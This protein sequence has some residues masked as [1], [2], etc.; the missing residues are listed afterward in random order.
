MTVG[1]IIQPV[2]NSNDVPVLDIASPKGRFGGK[3]GQM[4]H[5]IGTEK[6]GVMHTSVEPG[7]RAFSSYVH[8]GIEELFY[9]IDGEGEYRFG[10]TACPVRSGDVLAGHLGGDPGTKEFAGEIEV[11]AC[12]TLEN[13][14]ATLATVNASLTNIL[15]CQVFLDDNDDFAAMNGV[16]RT[17]FSENPPARTMVAVSDL[18]LGAKIEIE[19]HS[20]VQRRRQ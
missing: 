14:K 11:E 12:Q 4:R 2:L 8:H 17:Y 18:S 9:I 20:H 13:N 5:L 10:E 3:I 1:D 16:D 19:W 6:I 15:R 7:K